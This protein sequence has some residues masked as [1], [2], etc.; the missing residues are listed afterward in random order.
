MNLDPRQHPPNRR[1][2]PSAHNVLNWTRPSAPRVSQPDSHSGGIGDVLHRP[3]PPLTSPF[4]DPDSGRGTM[5][6]HMPL[7][8]APGGRLWLQG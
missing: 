7:A 4:G 2:P 6:C 3:P 5:S 8:D 1:A